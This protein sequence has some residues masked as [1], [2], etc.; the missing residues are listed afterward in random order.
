MAPRTEQAAVTAAGGDDG[1]IINKPKY[2]KKYAVGH[3]EDANAGPL[4]IHLYGKRVNVTNWLSKH[5]GGRKV[6][7]VFQDRDA[8]EQFEA[9]HSKEARKQ[10][11]GFLNKSEP[12][13]E[14]Q[15]GDTKFFENPV[16]KDMV[17]LRQKLEKQGLFKPNILFEVT[18]LLYVFG[19]ILGG[20]YIMYAFPEHLYL[21][22]LLVILGW[23]Q[24]GWVGHDY[25]HHSVFASPVLN[26]Q[27][28]TIVGALQGYN[29]M[30][31][32]A[33]HNTHHVVTNEVGNDPDIKTSPLFHFIQQY[34]D[35]NKKL[36]SIQRY[37][38]I[39][40]VPAMAI[41]DLYWR[42]ESIEFIARR[43]KK[44]RFD[45]LLL[46]AHYTGLAFVYSTTGFWPIYICML[47]RGWLTGL[48]VFS[49]HYA[50]ERIDPDAHMPFLEQT[51]RT[52]HNIS[53]SSLWHFF[54]GYISMQAEH[55]LFPTMPRS[56][57]P[58]VQPLVRELC[59]KHKLPY[60]EDNII[61]C[62]RHN[63]RSLTPKKIE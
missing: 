43:F 41:L 38:H 23:H 8:T 54:T 15:S 55:H 50:E 60:G 7:H 24:A 2:N 47:V 39:Y 32:K 10:L 40:Y 49:S 19:S 42:F 22:M 33:R 9:M 59:L 17:E 34:P 62:V 13:P 53:G 25:S 45:A 28:S 51:V 12:V 37:Q 52:S 21:G 27:V 5:P 11:D 29:L 30:W 6:L 44:M 46:V 16:R 61:E 14:G 20:Q 58:Y 48:I 35:L 57:L 31:W 26:D 36:K 1:A 56:N 4:F 18:K 3:K 63:I